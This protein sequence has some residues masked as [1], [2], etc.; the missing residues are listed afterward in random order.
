[1]KILK[2]RK[3]NSSKQSSYYK[4]SKNK[5]KIKNILLKA[6]FKYKNKIGGR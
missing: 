5:K 6:N 2:I 3:D 4:K 1:M